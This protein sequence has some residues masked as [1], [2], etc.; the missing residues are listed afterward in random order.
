MT[1]KAENKAAEYSEKPLGTPK[2]FLR[3]RHT[4]PC[5]SKAFDGS[6]SNC[7]ETEGG[8]PA[9][10]ALTPYRDNRTPYCSSVIPPKNCPHFYHHLIIK[11]HPGVLTIVPTMINTII[12]N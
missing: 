3:R 9:S 12:D 6:I 4:A 11:S 1:I 7:M 10:R 2:T 5:I 8:S